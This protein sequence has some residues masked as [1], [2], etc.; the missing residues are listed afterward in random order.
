MQNDFRQ[1]LS[2]IVDLAG[3]SRSKLAKEIGVDKSVVSRWT[4]G[5]TRPSAAS[6]DQLTENLASRVNGLRR[7]DWE[8]PLTAFES[9]FAV[10]PLQGA[11][12]ASPEHSDESGPQQEVKFCKT[13][14]GVHLAVASMGN[15]PVL[16]K[17]PNWLT[18]VD[19]DMT[20]PAWAPTLARLARHCR[21]VRYDARGNGL[22]DCSA[23][24]VDFATSVRDLGSVIDS[25]GQQKV[26]ILGISQ[27]AA[28]AVAY[29]AANPGRVERLCLHGGYARGRQRRGNEMEIKKS[30]LIDALIMTGWGS[31]NPVYLNALASLF[32][33]T[34]SPDQIRSFGQLQRVS[35]TAENILQMKR[36]MEEID[37][38]EL[39]SKVVAPTLVTHARRDQ[40]A[41]IEEG[42][43][44]AAGIPGA[45]FASLESD[46]H[47]I[48]P[49]EPAWERWMALVEAFLG[50]A[51]REG[52]EEQ[53]VGTP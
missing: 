42:R 36:V 38:T 9:K 19:Y 11:L 22:S 40:I 12:N 27:G 23:G 45:S 25:I 16:V 10:F 44:L 6:L 28:I 20:S 48:L 13:P 4:S 8:L 47:V 41:T 24:P 35:A 53:K 18:H 17:A 33:P 32:I 51:P 3:L 50:T 29:A 21:F 46:N 34:A 39:L 31:D 52:T 14:V 43:L 5:A 15:G 37:I 49:G 1:K 26:S 2:L 30:G 7:A